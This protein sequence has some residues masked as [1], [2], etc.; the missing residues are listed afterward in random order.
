MQMVARRAR[1][2]LGHKGAPA[3]ESRTGT[4]LVGPAAGGE[5]K[6]DPCGTGPRNLKF[7]ALEHNTVSTDDPCCSKGQIDN[8]T[9]V[10]V[11]YQS[12][13]PGILYQCPPQKRHLQDT[14]SEDL[15]SNML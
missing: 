13:S 14:A 4:R 3:R 6:N 1:E 15:D 9:I 10:S 5:K 2:V 11:G 8:F 12:T 7:G